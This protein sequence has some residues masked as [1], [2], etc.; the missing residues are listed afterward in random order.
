MRQLRRC[1]VVA[2]RTQIIQ[3][4]TRAKNRIHSILHADLIPPYQGEVFSVAGRAWL[5]TQPQALDEKLATQRHLADLDC[6]ASDLTVLGRQLAQRALNDKRVEP[7]M[8]I[9]GIHV[10]VALGLLA[11]IGDIGRFEGGEG[12][13]ARPQHRAGEVGPSQIGATQLGLE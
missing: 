3:Q 13:V 2:Q 4:M 6:R 7:L 11:A 10:T 1:G 9:S 5:D 12:E 8:T